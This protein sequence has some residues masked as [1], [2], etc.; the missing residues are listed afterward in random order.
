MIKKLQE[1]GIFKIV[2]FA[3]VLLIP[4]IY[5][6]FYLKSYWNP[7]EHLTDIK[8]G[9]VNLDKGE[10]GKNRGK[11]LLNELQ[12]SGVMN[13]VEVESTEAAN[14]GLGEDEYYAIITIP[15]DFTKTLNSAPTDNKQIS[16]ITY[17]PNKR[18]NYLS[19]QIINSALKTVEINLQS[20]V[21]KEVTATLSNS[22][23]DV[24]DNLQKIS[25][26][27]EQIDDGAGKLSDGLQKLASGADTLDKKYS[28]FDKGIESA[29]KGSTDLT[30]GVSQINSGIDNLSNGANELNGAIEQINEGAGILSNQGSLGI[31]KLLNGVEELYK[32]A[33]G[34][35][36]GVSEYVAGTKTLA[37]GTK[38]YVEG[39]N[40]LSEGIKSYVTN[41]N[42]L[43]NGVQNYVTNAEDLENGIV[44]YVNGVN[45]VTTQKNAVLSSL[46]Q[47][48]NSNPND[49][50]IKQL[51]INAQAILDA[52]DSNH[53]SA[54]GQALVN[55]ANGLKANNQ[56]LKLLAQ[57]LQSNNEN[58]TNGANTLQAY[59]ADLNGGASQLINK[60]DELTQGSQKLFNGV[61]QL[62]NETADLPQLTSGIKT[63][64]TAISQV[65]TGTETL[66]SGVST[67]KDGTNRVQNGSVELTKGLNV[68]KTSS[69]DVKN[70]L[71]QISAGTNQSLEGSATLK[72]GTTEYKIQINDGLEKAKEEVKKL[73]DLDNYVQ[74][75]VQFKEESYGKVDSY[76]V[77]FAPLFISIGLWV[78]A[79]MCY[80]VLYYDQRHRFG[81]L[82]HD[83]QKSKIIQNVLYLAI[84]AIEGVLTGLLLKWTLGYSVVHMGTYVWQ[85][86]LAG[87]VF[88]SVI[89]F[90]IRNFGDI[91]KFLALIILVLQLAASGGTF[92]VETIDNAFKGFTNILPM[93]YTI[94]A[95]RDALVSTD[96][97]LIMTN[98]WVLIG[99]FVVLNVIN[100]S[101]EIFK[102]KRKKC[103]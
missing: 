30:N 39:A 19:S 14:K 93:T 94:R 103:K 100:L 40:T 35:N 78:G 16:T 13:F 72:E 77:A 92:P 86:M 96:H 87:L 11:E 82:D 53:M 79:L 20:K 12:N 17:S 95:F 32:G 47:Y 57:G 46:I 15:E 70:A 90:L 67:L 61:G 10:N 91:G 99:I 4:V 21:S 59:N 68:L 101:V 43:E 37:Q 26:G 23:K 83:T 24:P 50:T 60:A 34:L 45:S 7:Y 42:T 76:G 81:I 44:G 38:E 56:S 85:C 89:Q 73:D 6:F 64:R 22:L 9:I 69:K 66:V 84:G 55:G 74:D 51:A 71:D 41:A 31:F 88:M 33:D 97:S 5:S 49:E 102:E 58:L 75:P 8:V 1:K 63:L 25:D 36:S 28:E 48:S 65:N 80:V 27:A 52:E 98:T 18:K 54:Q 29:T 3:V 62:K 2:V